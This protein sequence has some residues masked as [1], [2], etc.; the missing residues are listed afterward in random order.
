MSAIGVKAMPKISPD[1]SGHGLFL[2]P[3]VGV[4][5]GSSAGPR[6]PQAG[7]DMARL[8]RRGGDMTALEL[9]AAVDAHA[10]GC[11]RCWNFDGCTDGLRMYDTWEAAAVEAGL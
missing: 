8:L 4:W 10:R 3:V 1:P 2:C 5:W 9:Q 6:S 11:E 7:G